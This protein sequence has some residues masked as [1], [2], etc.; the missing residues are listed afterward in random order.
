MNN[1]LLNI[2]L[3]QGNQFNIYQNKI[4]N[5]IIKRG[6]INTKTYNNHK[7][8]EFATL[9]QKQIVRPNLYESS[10][11][12]KNIE[13][14]TASINNDNQQ[15]L[16]DVNNLKIK[17]DELIKKYNDIQPKIN[18]HHLGS[19]IDYASLNQVSQEDQIIYDNVISQ[20]IIIGNDIVSKMEKL[21]N[22]DNKIFER[23]NTNKEQFIKDLEKYKLT[24]LNIKK[25]LSGS[26]NN[27]MKNES[28]Q[29]LTNSPNIN[30]LSGMLSD[31]DLRVLKENYSYILWSI[32][33]V[34]ILTITIN[35]IKK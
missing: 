22:Q 7:I 11:L 8:E 20:L 31:S 21:Y 9:A 35:T 16:E 25:K 34:G 2:S 5:N 26:Q 27:S 15:D 23:L 10:K 4:K 1:D 29:N 13:E 33:A 24:N 14:N 17:Y 12:L 32:L 6:N 28:I 19:T 18:Q 3:E 30:D